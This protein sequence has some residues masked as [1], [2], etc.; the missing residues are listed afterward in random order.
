MLLASVTPYD[1][2][3]THLPEN[4]VCA[5]FLAFYYHV[6]LVR[7]TQAGSALVEVKGRRK[8]ENEL[9]AVER[10]VYVR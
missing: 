4:H 5:D 10:P 2:E 3:V 7:F 9:F 1:I 8:P 6:G